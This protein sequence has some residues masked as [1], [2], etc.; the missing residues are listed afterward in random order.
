MNTYY[1]KE[2]FTPASPAKVAFVER[3]KINDKLVSALQ[4]PGKQIIVYGHSGSGK[5][6]LLVNK[7]KQLYENHITTRCMKGLT[8]EQL[9]IDGFDQ[10]DKY[11]ISEKTK[12]IA[13]SVS[14]EFTSNYF[15]IQAKLNT[16]NTKSEQNK[17]FRV[18][19]PQL[20]PQALGKFLGSAKCCW[21]LE[22]FHKIDEVEKIKLSQLMKVFM[23]LSEE[24]EDLKI[25]A[26][27]AVDSASQV[28]DYDR[29]MRNRVAE[30]H[31][32][33]MSA[34]EIISIIEKGEEALNIA[35]DVNLKNL[36]ANYS[37]G[38]ASVCHHLCTYMCNAAG[39]DKTQE[40]K[41]VLSKANFEE[42]LKLYVEESSDSIRSAFENAVKQR[43]KATFDN[44]N[45]IL[46]ALS[47]FDEKGASRSKLLDTIRK[48]APRYPETN[49]KY[50]LTKLETTEYSSLIRYS[51]ISGRF[52]FADPFYRVYAL[53]NY[54]KNGNHNKSLS[55]NNIAELLDIFRKEFS[56]IGSVKIEIRQ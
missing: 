16:E 43:R 44:A 36:I 49:L 35:F 33:L 27:G 31:V 21:I 3:A 8:F 9:L 22:D 54:S 15:S 6:T 2:V 5:T 51:S 26:L 39:I 28:V 17:E 32:E 10:L 41:S 47:S 23:D 55:A 12:G 20:T 25:V 30:I 4:M 56:K 37:N 40:T 29:E 46:E 19:P 18:L 14:S 42:A 38:L 34:E 13:S 24:H 50:F 1:L 7:L 45:L 11:Y 53:A 48:K 52:S